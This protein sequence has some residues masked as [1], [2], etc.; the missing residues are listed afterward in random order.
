[1]QHLIFALQ[2]AGLIFVWGLFLLAIVCAAS[3]L[4]RKRRRAAFIKGNSRG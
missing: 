2:A 4:S 1:M 3:W